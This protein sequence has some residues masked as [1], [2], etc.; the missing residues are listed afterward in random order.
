MLS[1]AEALT[2]A[3]RR[4]GGADVCVVVTVGTGTQLQVFGGEVGCPPGREGTVGI[5]AAPGVVTIWEVTCVAVS[6][7][8]GPKAID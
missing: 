2:A 1:S 8:A 6:G 4:V 5:L 7:V 3:G